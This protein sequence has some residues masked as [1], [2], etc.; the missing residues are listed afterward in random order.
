MARSNRERGFTLV[1]VLIA[2]AV[3]AIAMGALIKGGGQS[4]QTMDHLRNKTFANWVALNS[5]S[6]I[7]LSKDWPVKSR[8]KGVEEMA[9]KRWQ[10]IAESEDTFD[11]NVKRIK[12]TVHDEQGD[13][14]H[15]AAT[16]YAYVAKP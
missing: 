3:L 15:A 7:Q 16:F 8:Q 12:V 11:E 13:P 5:V 10:W 9:G 2:L 14:K 4:A 1:E 6:Q